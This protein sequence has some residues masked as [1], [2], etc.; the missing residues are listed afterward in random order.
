MVLQ[1]QHITA[2]IAMLAA[3]S[4]T[5]SRCHHT[6]TAAPG[7]DCQQQQQQST[8]DA[9]STLKYTQREAPPTPAAP[10]SSGAQRPQ[11]ARGVGRQLATCV[12][13]K[14]HPPQHHHQ[15]Q[16]LPLPQHQHQPPSPARAVRTFS[17][18]LMLWPQTL[19]WLHLHPH[20]C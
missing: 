4:Q 7:H 19:T 11:P 15:Q 16:Q 6:N 13:W 20:S 10:A 17:G 14:H 5:G 2:H 1:R 8:A 12:S 18:R 3:P 9:N